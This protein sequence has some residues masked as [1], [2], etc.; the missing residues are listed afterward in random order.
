MRAVLVALLAFPLTAFAQDTRGQIAGTV[1]DAQSAIV[2]GA[3]VTIVN[4]G[5]NT[6]V[7]LATNPSGYFEAPLLLSG[8][9]TVTVE[10]A[11]FKRH[12]RS[13]VTL[14]IGEQVR[15]DLQLEVG[16][17]TES[18][19]IQAEAPMLETSSVS[20]GRAMTHREVMDLPVLGNNITM[21]TRFSPGVQVPGTTQFL[22]QGQ[23]GGGSGYSAAGGVGGNEWSMDGASTNGTDRRVSF[24][25]S[26][27]VVDEFRIETSNFD[28]A[29]GH[30]TGL[31]ISMSTKSGANAYHGSATYQYINQRWNAASFFVKK[32]RY[33][34]IATLRNAGN[35]REA[36]A[37]AATP[38]LPAGHT[39]NAHATI[40]G[41][42]RI[43]KLMD[44]RN[45]LFFFLGYSYLKNQQAARPSEI[46]YTVPTL[47]MRG[48]DFSRLL[49]ADA[50]RYQLYDPLSARPDP[51]RPG[52]IIRN[53]FA[54]NI[55]PRARIINP[56]A[57][58]YNKRMPVPNN[59]PTDP[60]REPFNNYLATGMPNNVD[61]NSWNNRI[62]YQASNSHRFFFRWLKSHF[63]EDAQDF[64]YET[65]PGLMAWNE[66]RPTVSGLFD[67]T[68]VKSAST[69][70]NISVDATRFLTQNQRLG[71]RKY[72]P[73][74]VVCP[75]IWM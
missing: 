67:W 26:P 42:I 61:Y 45:K 12:V 1:I 59:D 25:P 75:H 21:L 36:D 40:S 37:L 4:T 44:G 29:F 68:Y 58:F 18:I 17:T 9:Y 8:T 2:A 51:A 62:D 57:E 69:V 55:I 46:N 38:M 49:Q 35:F 31:N 64:T 73:T 39:N 6:S 34:Q 7:V 32:A 72:K 53:A 52:H 10:M 28:A 74:D 15:L 19:T 5:T 54:G 16:A 60:R 27:D 71:T 65:E 14:G 33:E 63:I 47:A 30:A 13:G 3:A 22:V 70:M 48:G 11:G 20:T 50:V 41:P 56:M 66:K 43:P 23:V 24:M